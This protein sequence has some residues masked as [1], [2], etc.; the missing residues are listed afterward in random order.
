MYVVA[1]CR[2][3]RSDGRLF[4]GCDGDVSQPQRVLCCLPWLALLFLPCLFVLASVLLPLAV[5]SDPARG[6][7]VMDVSR[8]EAD[9]HR[10]VRDPAD[11]FAAVGFGLWLLAEH[12]HLAVSIDGRRDALNAIRTQV[13]LQEPP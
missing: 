5:R 10:G 3:R 11:D 2:T 6:D 8:I 12:F 4:F 13:V 1:C 7:L 9:A